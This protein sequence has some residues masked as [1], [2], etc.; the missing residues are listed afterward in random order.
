[1]GRSMPIASLRR[2]KCDCLFFERISEKGILCAMYLR[3]QKIGAL[4]HPILREHG[5]TSL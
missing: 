5:N 2:L 1:M 3:L 4:S